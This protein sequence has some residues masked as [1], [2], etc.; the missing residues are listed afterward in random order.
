MITEIKLRNF[1]SHRRLD[2]KLDPGVNVIIGPSDAGK[3]AIV[4]ALFWIAFNQ[5]AG[6]EFRSHWGGRTVAMLKTDDGRLVKRV[7]TKYENY[8]QLDKEKLKAFGRGVPEEVSEV[9]N[10][11]RVNFMRQLDPPFLLS[12]TPAQVAKELNEVANLKQVD[13]SIK[14][15]VGELRRTQS[16]IRFTEGHISDLTV[17]LEEY[18]G[19][20]EIEE[21]V[22]LAEDLL[23]RRNSK[24]G[25]ASNIRKAVRAIH[26]EE[27]RLEGLR[28]QYPADLAA[29][30]DKALVLIDK[31]V[32]LKRKFNSITK[33]L[34]R[35]ET[36]KNEIKR[37]RERAEKLEAELHDN[38]EGQPCPLCGRT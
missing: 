4:R 3:S 9:L 28:N 5:P 22:A 26:E 14:W 36:T 10:L 20:D 27:R 18:K 34:D 15:I 23:K 11:N 37:K 6:D 31:S 21:Q 8:Y 24:Y 19:L 32:K 33:V 17:D 12:S 2:M 1:Q 35:I 38:L 30:V 25:Q 29:T 7:R 16:E 13:S